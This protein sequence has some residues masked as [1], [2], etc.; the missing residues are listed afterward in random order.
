[1]LIEGGVRP[2]FPRAVSRETVSLR[3]HVKLSFLVDP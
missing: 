3:F 2:V 1:M